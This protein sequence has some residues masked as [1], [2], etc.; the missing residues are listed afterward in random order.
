MARSTDPRADL[1]EGGVE[2]NARWLN[3]AEFIR[4]LT[5]LAA[6][7]PPESR[8]REFLEEYIE[9]LRKNG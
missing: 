8:T 4:F 1:E 2:E 3:K 9:D 7:Y 5:N 6:N